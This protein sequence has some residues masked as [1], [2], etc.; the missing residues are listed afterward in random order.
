ME[1]YYNDEFLQKVNNADEAWSVAVN[2]LRGKN[3][4]PPYY[5]LWTEDG[6]TVIDFG[7]HVDF[8]YFKP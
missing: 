8:I 6:K 5:R 4:E 7:S 3:I 2:L 1:V